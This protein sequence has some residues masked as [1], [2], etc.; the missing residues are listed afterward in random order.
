MHIHGGCPRPPEID[1]LPYKGKAM[2]TKTKKPKRHLPVEVPTRAEVNQLLQTCGRRSLSGIRDRAILA[3]MAGC[4]L[5]VSETLALHVRD[6][7]FD[8][9]SIVVQHG[10][11]DKRRVCGVDDGTLA[12]LRTWLTARKALVG[13]SNALVFVLVSKGSVG[14]SVQAVAVRQ[15]MKR[16]AEKAGISKRCHP[17]AL[18]HFHAVSLVNDLV[19]LPVIAAQLGQASTSTTDRYVQHLQNG[20]VVAAIRAR[21][22]A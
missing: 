9:G 14:R 4:G 17:H 5:R 12:I 8:K 22:S 11:G 10:K 3:T 15:M 13:R 19:P 20:D 18:R 1:A 6:I 16:R 2:P 21:P 7:D